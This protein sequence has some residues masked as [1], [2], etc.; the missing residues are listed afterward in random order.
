MAEQISGPGKYAQ[1][2]DMNT[3]KQPVRYM[4]GGN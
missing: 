4:A 2:T 1:R 3:S